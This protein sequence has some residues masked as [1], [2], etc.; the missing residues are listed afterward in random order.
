V[1]AE[2]QAAGAGVRGVATKTRR[3]GTLVEV[4]G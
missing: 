4:D 1:A 2:L 3:G